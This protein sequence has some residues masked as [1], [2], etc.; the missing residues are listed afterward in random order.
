LKI[1][2]RYIFKEMTATFFV[3]I[4]AFTVTLLLGKIVRLTEMIVTKGVGFWL[5]LR[6]FLLMVPSFLVVT[7]PMATLLATV[8][9]F[10][11]MA[12]DKEVV[13]LKASGVS[14]YR[15][16]YTPALFAILACVVNLYLAIQVQPWGNRNF[17][18]LLVQ[19]ARTQA[20]LGLREGVFNSDLEGFIIYIRNLKGEGRVLEGILLAD[21]RE[22]ESFKVIVARKGEV[23][24]DPEGVKTI[25]RLS[26]GS[27]HFTYPKNPA[28]YRELSFNRYELN[29]DLNRLTDNP[30]EKK[31][32]DREMTFSELLDKMGGENAAQRHPHIFTEFHKRFSIPFAA[33]VFILIGTPLGIRVKRSGKVSGFS[34]SVALV[35]VYYLLFSLGE[36][37]GNKGKISPFLA[38]WFPNLLLGGLGAGLLLLEGKE[39]W[40]EWSSWFRR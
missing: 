12:S 17:R 1:L 39:K 38:V 13:A 3:G 21:T 40:P 10:G 32:I 11:R 35:L 36:A 14:L 2:D 27:I 7:I 33:I 28:N 5:I 8:S 29:L 6:L 20:G 19:V 4:G 15:L 26:D 34:L 16:L 30:L 9:T 18:N 23:I 37:L 24:I 22:E 25:L 31:K